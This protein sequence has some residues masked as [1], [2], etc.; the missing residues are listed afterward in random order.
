MVRNSANVSAAISFG[1]VGISL[2]IKIVTAF[3]GIA[4][5]SACGSLR[6]FSLLSSSAEVET[7]VMQWRLAGN[8]FIRK[9]TPHDNAFC[10]RVPSM[11]S[12]QKSDTRYPVTTAL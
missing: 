5:E 12:K 7:T 8:D 1:S 11:L 6:A 3:R 4:G 2:R 10:A 9:H